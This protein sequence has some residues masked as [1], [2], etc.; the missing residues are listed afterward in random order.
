MHEGLIARNVEQLF[1]PF[2]Y[3][4]NSRH[5]LIFTQEFNLL[6]DLVRMYHP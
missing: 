2:H 6:Q 4:N 5:L 3:N 1:F